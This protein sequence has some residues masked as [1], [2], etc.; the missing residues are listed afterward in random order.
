MPKT[1]KDIQGWYYPLSN[2]D[3]PK[4]MHVSNSKHKVVKKI[5]KNLK[6]HYKIKKKLK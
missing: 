6:G 3:I 2:N 4:H 1:I 5:A